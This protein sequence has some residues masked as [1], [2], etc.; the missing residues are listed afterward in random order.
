MF[1][2]IIGYLQKLLNES[3]YFHDANC[4]SL[5]RRHYQSLLRNIISL[6]PLSFFS[7]LRTHNKYTILYL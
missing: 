1:N 5:A 3:Y 6:R 4:V 2:H 7:S